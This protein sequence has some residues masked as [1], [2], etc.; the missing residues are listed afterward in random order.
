M[1]EQF[2]DVCQQKEDA[3]RMLQKV[4]QDANSWRAKFEGEAMGKI[5]ELEASKM[6][7]QARL[8]ESESA[9]ENLNNKLQNLDRSKLIT[10]KNIDNSRHK[11]DQAAAKQGQA[12]KKV[13][14]MDRVVAD[15]RGKADEI[16]RELVAAQMEQ[17]NIASELFRVKN[18]KSEADQQ[19]EEILRENKSLSDEI[20]EL[21]EQISDGGRTIHEIEKKRKKTEM[22]KTDLECALTDAESTLE[23]E[24]NKL[25]KLTLEINQ[26]KSDIDKRILEKEEEFEST[27]KNHCKAM[28]HLQFAIEE[29]SKHKAE[30]IRSKK[31]LE[32]DIND[33]DI[34]LKR[35]TLES[36]THTSSIKRLQ[37]NVRCKTEDV[38]NARRDTD[39]D[40]EYLINVERKA[41][42]LKNAVEESRAML[43]QADKAR[44]VAEQELS[45]CLEE[46]SKLTFKQATLD[47]EKRKLEADMAE[48]QVN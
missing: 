22:E 45:D 32:Q 23:F 5:E 19:L 11:V 12:E 20:K 7:L 14:M 29:E 35:S 9:V 36:S 24:E 41:S 28:E 47:S 39:N 31:K 15:W 2:G 40:R 4:T 16:A 43:E 42:N 8:S 26:L 34:S 44:R 10:E 13:K 6:K 27:K 30:A 17:R 48:L 1:R 25:L 46:N 3:V 18:G 37:E 33:L 21:M 38:E